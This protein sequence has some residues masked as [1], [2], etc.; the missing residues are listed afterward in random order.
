MGV[1]GGGEETDGRRVQPPSASGLSP[2]RGGE[3]RSA[4]KEAAEDRTLHRN[5][6]ERRKDRRTPDQRTQHTPERAIE[7]P[8]PSGVLANQESEALVAAFRRGLDSREVQWRVP[9]S[10]ASFLALRLCLIPCREPADPC[11]KGA[12]LVD[13]RSPPRPLPP[14]PGAVSHRINPRSRLE[15]PVQ[16]HRYPHAP[17]PVT[18]HELEAA[19][20]GTL[21]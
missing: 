3:M 7:L 18:I 4:R 1:T 5:I 15:A 14:P 8:L 13:R 11:G 19:E 2:R 10:A 6:G 12:A 20:D 9:S 17:Q 16:G 21:H